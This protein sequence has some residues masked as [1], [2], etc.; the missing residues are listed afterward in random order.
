M[1]WLFTSI[2]WATIKCQTSELSAGE[3]VMN[4]IHETQ[5]SGRQKNNVWKC[6]STLLSKS[7]T[8]VKNV[9]CDRCSY[10]M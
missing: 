10:K 6:E 3:S 4:E 2:S 1:K 7:F 5:E 8:Q 9:K